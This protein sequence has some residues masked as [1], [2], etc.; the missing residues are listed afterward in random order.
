MTFYHSRLADEPSIVSLLVRVVPNVANSVETKVF[1]KT[2]LSHQLPYIK[3]LFKLHAL[4][5]TDVQNIQWNNRLNHQSFRVEQPLGVCPTL[6]NI[7]IQSGLKIQ[8]KLHFALGTFLCWMVHSC[9]L[10]FSWH[11]HSE[12]IPSLRRVW[13]YGILRESHLIYK[14]E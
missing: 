4:Y 6:N 13:R 7:I 11:Y 10:T 3:L 2:T 1:H 5:Y 14:R 12:T 9:W 8:L